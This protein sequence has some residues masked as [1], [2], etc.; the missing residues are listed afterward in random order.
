MNSRVSGQCS[1][2]MLVLN[3]LINYKKTQLTNYKMLLNV[4]TSARLR[5]FYAEEE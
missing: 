1:N 5:G 2:A 3:V 4:Y